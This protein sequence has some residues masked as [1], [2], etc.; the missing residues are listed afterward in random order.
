MKE[1]PCW[2]TRTLKVSRMAII[3]TFMTL[4]TFC[5]IILKTIYFDHKE[6]ILLTFLL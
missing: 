1:V 6:L 2:G 3:S 5:L 4:E